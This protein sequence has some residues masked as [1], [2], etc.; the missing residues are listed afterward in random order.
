MKRGIDN[1]IRPSGEETAGEQKTDENEKVISEE[2]ITAQVITDEVKSKAETG[3]VDE[4][5][6]ETETAPRVKETPVSTTPID[7]DVFEKAL[8]AGRKNPR[9]IIWSPKASVALRALRKTIP[10]F[11]ISREA[12]EL[13]E[14]GIRRKYPEIWEM[15]EEH[16]EKE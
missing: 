5:M 13:L 15:V 4:P 12:S 6:S 16:F 7:R 8:E 2:S 10:E 11:S 9:V 14:E 3:K 1:L